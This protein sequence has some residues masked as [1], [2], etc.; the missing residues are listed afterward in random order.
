MKCIDLTRRQFMYAASASVAGSKI[1]GL[2][3][4][5]PAEF[6]Q[7]RPRSV[8]LL[9]GSLLGDAMGGPLEF[10]DEDKRK[11]NVVGARGWDPSK[12]LKRETVAEIANRASLMSYE[13][14][15]PGVAA[16]GPWIER[17]PAGTL[18]D[19]SRWKIVLIRAIQMAKLESKPLSRIHIA[20]AILNF[21]PVSNQVPD[22]KTLQLVEEGLREYRYAANWM[23][24]ERD[25]KIALPLARL[26]AGIPNCSGQMMMLP[27]AIRYAGDSE[28]AYRQSYALNFVDSAPAKDIASVIVAALASV[29]GDSANGWSI[30]KRWDTIYQTMKMLDPF[31]LKKVPFAGRPL[32]KWLK[33]IDEI[34]E[35]AN[36][37]PAEAYRLLETKAK[38]EF[39]WDA[40]FKII[41][42]LT[43]LRICDHNPM[44]A[45][46]LAIDF[47]HDTDSYAQ[48]I[49]AF[50]GAVYG[51][52][53]FPVEMRE[54]VIKRLKAEYDED[55]QQWVELLSS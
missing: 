28:K 33:I 37:R 40:H 8:G 23:L 35:Q 17:A 54:T 2:P 10:A 55:V 31:R 43:L 53:A 1:I 4:N 6:A 14:V 34:V 26:W 19:D 7:T 9:I 51:P 48:L 36:G 3:T 20:R 13:K 21:R 18:T 47:G 16:Y 45:L 12:K 27:L 24:G 38:P 29:L 42:A 32:D 46:A 30:D 22:A 5:G 15:R 50:A 49:G 25:E 52:E 39:F 44:C 41:V 11:G